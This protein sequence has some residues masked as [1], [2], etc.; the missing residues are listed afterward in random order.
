MGLSKCAS[1]GRIDVAGNHWL[2][3]W[4]DMPTDPKWRT[5]ARVSGRRIG[6]V[7]AVY[8]HLL[9]AASN[10]DERGRTHS[11]NC[12]DVA[13]ALDLEIEDVSA[14]VDAMQTRVLDGDTVKGWAKRQPAREDG[15]AE[16]AKAWREA[17]KRPDD[18]KRTQPNAGER[19]Q[20]LREEEIRERE[21]KERAR[22]LAE[23]LARAGEVDPE[24]PEDPDDPEDPPEANGQLPTPAGLVCRAMRAAGMSAVNPGDPRLLALLAQGATTDEL[25]GIASEAVEKQKGWAWV[26]HVVE[27]RRR[28]AAEISLAP[29]PAEANASAELERSAAYLAEQEA[30]RRAAAS[31]E[32]RERARQALAQARSALTRVTQ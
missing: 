3:L 28:E 25:V 9:V 16:R 30:H 27:S 8:L 12:E 1:S 17:K 21:E 6:D 24:D 18:Q 13:T 2:R 26:L 10:A 22:A 15:S 32:N 5:I 23:A 4:H 31:P 29:K 11:F 7:M 19:A 14:I 20:T